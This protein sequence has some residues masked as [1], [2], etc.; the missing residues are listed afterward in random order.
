M[1]HGI[2]FTNTYESFITSNT[3]GDIYT[4]YKLIIIIITTNFYSA[5][6]LERIKFSGTPSTRFGQSHS[7]DTLQNSSIN[8]WLQLMYICLR[9]DETYCNC[10]DNNRITTLFN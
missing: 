7:Q 8:D 2:Y 1:L 5:N 4:C 10:Y 3:V 9:Y 6:V